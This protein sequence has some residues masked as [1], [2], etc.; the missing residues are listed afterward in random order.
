MKNAL[1][2]L[3]SITSTCLICFWYQIYVTG[4]YYHNAGLFLAMIAA[5]IP[6]LIIYISFILIRYIKNK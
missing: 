4:N 2:I 1:Y 5:L 3:I 6:F